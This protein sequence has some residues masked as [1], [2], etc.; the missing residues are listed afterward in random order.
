MGLENLPIQPEKRTIK[1]LGKQALF[2]HSK[3]R[4]PAMFGGYASGKTTAGCLIGID[5]CLRYPGCVGAVIRNT[6][7]EL[8]TSTKKVFVDLV[9]KIDQGKSE[10]EK[11]VD[12]ENEQ[13][14]YMRFKN[15]STVFFM[16]TSSEGLYKGP[17][18]GWFFIDQAEELLEDTAQRITTR[19][20]QPGMPQ[21]GMF[22][23][24]TDKGHNWCYR[25]FKLGQKA[26]TE[27][28][29][30]SFLD[31]IQNLDRYYVEEMLA[32]PEDWK[33]V[34]LY[35]S[36]DSPGGLVIEPTDDHMVD[37]FDVPTIWPK[38][39]AL[40]PAESTGI[41]AALAFTV[42]RNGNRFYTGEYYKGRRIIKDHVPGILKLW[43][44]QQRQ[45][46]A[47]PNSWR[48]AQMGENDFVT[49][50]DRFRECGLY[51]IPA[52]NAITPAVDFIREL[53]EPDPEHSHPIT[54]RT[55]APRMY[56]FK[57]RLT[58]FFEELRGWM[59]DAPDK[60]PVHL[61]DCL[62]YSILAKVGGPSF[63]ERT[64]YFRKARSFMGL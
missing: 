48:K 34:N 61:M 47:D 24:N 62:R 8:R 13:Y 31:N 23:G 14:N 10:S 57:G 37:P 5:Y 60:E 58:H 19:L 40:D 20:R 64:R 44:G 56:F 26:N 9:H 35:G 3:A 49:I 2:A 18:F 52:A 12:T 59:I 6:N 7:P 42:D 63:K 36:W 55:P 43:E 4:Y 46:F 28:F 1:L 21:K 17:E 30:I 54:G 51:A 16:H 27:L 45:I 22:V 50:A 33:K 38:Y 32:Y 29:D 41:C 53:H 25:W 39:I 11:V 15:G